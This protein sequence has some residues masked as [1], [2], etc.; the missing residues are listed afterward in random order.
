MFD[1]NQLQSA[2]S[3]ALRGA[4]AGYVP[5]SRAGSV[6]IYRTPN[7]PL[8]WRSSPQQWLSP[9]GPM[10][11]RQSV[12]TYQSCRGGGSG[13]GG[14]IG[15]SPHFHRGSKPPEWRYWRPIP[16]RRRPRAV[17]RRWMNGTTTGPETQQHFFDSNS[18]TRR[19]TKSPNGSGSDDAAFVF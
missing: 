4:C 12:Y 1:L 7:S 3:A 13:V 5:P 17:A 10:V 8:Q 2:P 14:D 16:G 19:E 15:R 18:K 9:V 6:P 11:F